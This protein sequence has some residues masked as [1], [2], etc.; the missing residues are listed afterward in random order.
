MAEQSPT[1]LSND[2]IVE[3]C[4]IMIQQLFAD[5]VIND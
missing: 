1:R 4:L 2:E 5:Q 3:N